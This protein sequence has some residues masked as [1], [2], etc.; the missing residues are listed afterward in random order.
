[1]AR[2]ADLRRLNKREQMRKM[3]AAII[4]R[5]FFVHF[6]VF[7]RKNLRKNLRV[8]R[9]KFRKRFIFNAYGMSAYSPGGTMAHL[10]EN[11]LFV[12]KSLYIS[13]P[14]FY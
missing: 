10:V 3:R 9:K 1:M 2:L 13:V 5:S 11:S 4:G 6:F 14:R 7:F 12:A 8:P